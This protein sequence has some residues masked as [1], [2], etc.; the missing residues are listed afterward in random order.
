MLLPA[1]LWV[2]EG[3][4]PLAP[5]AEEEGGTPVPPA[6]WPTP[7]AL[8]ALPPVGPVPVAPEVPV[9]DGLPTAP[10]E[11]GPVGVATGCG[12]LSGVP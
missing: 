11:V 5:A 4:L 1:P 8:S 2:F 3:P 9:S 12:R 6:S 10:V 7:V